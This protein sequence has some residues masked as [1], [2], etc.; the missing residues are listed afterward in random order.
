MSIFTNWKLN[1]AIVGSLIILALGVVL[2]KKILAGNASFRSGTY[3]ISNTNSPAWAKS[4]NAAPGDIV[5]FKVDIHNDGTET[6]TN[7]KV[8]ADLPTNVSGSSIASTIHV[9]ADNASEMTDTATAVLPASGNTTSLV[10]FPGHAVMIKHPGY[11]QSS[12]EAIGT[13]VTIDVGNLAPGD[14][15]FVEVTF[16]ATVVSSPT[17]TPTPTP[18]PSVTPAPTPTPTPVGGPVLQCPAGFVSQVQGSTIVCVQQTQSQSQTQNNNQTSN[19]TVS[20]SAPAPVV[21]TAPAQPQVVATA[22]APGV[23]TLPKTGLPLAAYS[24]AGLLPVGLK[25]RRFGKSRD[26]NLDDVNSIWES[27]NG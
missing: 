7:V 9:T 23:T 20:V 13:G 21:T 3:I 2:P 11:I 27:R 25:L 14:V 8:R 12:V 26:G 17:P 16:K 19:Q 1:L 6:A 10:Y 24:L 18:T 5:Q 15:N 22:A 4:V